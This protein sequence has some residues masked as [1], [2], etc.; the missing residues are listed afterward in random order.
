MT[1]LSIIQNAADRVGLVRPTSG[2][3]SS[4]TTTRQLVALSQQEGEELA[5][6]Y[7]WQAIIKEKTFTAVAQDAQT[8]AI[9]TDFDRFVP[10][11]FFN[12]SKRRQ[13]I[14]PLSAQEWQDQKGRLAT[15]VIDS[16]RQRG[17]QILITPTPTAGETYA[18][19]YV[20]LNWCQSADSD[21][22]SEWASDDDLGILDERL[23]TLGVMWRFLRAKGLDYAEAFRTYE[24]QV[25]QAIGRDGGS[26]RIHMGEAVLRYPSRPIVPDGD[27]P[28]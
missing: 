28:L 2:I 11:T 19:E 24:M 10:E 7:P 16:F 12:R 9:P 17:S 18:Y 4:D 21:E 1:L 5:R 27:W 8:D 6:R 23:I 22:Q 25:A 14:G 13:L 20:S 3:G 15:T 26:G